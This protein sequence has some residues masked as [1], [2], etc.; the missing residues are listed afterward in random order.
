MS[1]ISGSR[2]VDM[3]NN[4][5]KLCILA[6]IVLSIFSPNSYADFSAA[7]QNYK[8][9][10]YAE[11]MTEFKRSAVLGHKLSQFNIGIMYFNGEGVDKDIVEA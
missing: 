2:Y 1:K 8:N 11:A 4:N 5:F 7:I 9:K 6:A 10:N 3:W